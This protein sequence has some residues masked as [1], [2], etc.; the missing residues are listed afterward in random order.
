[1]ENNKYKQSFCIKQTMLLITTNHYSMHKHTKYK[2]SN[3]FFF[4][5]EHKA[6]KQSKKQLIWRKKK[7]IAGTLPFF[8]P[9]K[10]PKSQGKDTIQKV[11]HSKIFDLTKRL[12]FLKPI[13]SF[14]LRTKDID[15]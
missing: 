2:K 7:D 10:Y 15:N 1:M 11:F 5:S 8:L 9:V 14:I 4:N 13:H 12:L 3:D 6:F